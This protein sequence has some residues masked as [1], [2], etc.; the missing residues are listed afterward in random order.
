VP[1]L[2]W[3]YQNW[4]N[5]H[6]WEKAGDEWSAG[7][8]DA[9]SQWYGTILP[10]ISCFL[11]AKSILEIAPGFGRW[12]QFLLGNCDEYFGVDISERCIAKCK[13]R[14]GASNRVHFVQ[15]DGVSLN[16]IPD[17]HVDFVF[18]FDSLVHVDIDVIREYIWQIC[19]KL[20][21]T[22]IAFVHHSNAA[23]EQCDRSQAASIARSLNVSSA[24]VK[25][26]V[27]DC[28]AKV[29]IQEEVT[30]AGSTRID[31]L[32]T[33]GPAD[34]FPD[35]PYTLMQNDQFMLEMDL[36]RNYHRPYNFR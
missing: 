14:F 16:M 24:I 20:T 12:T 11:P 19:Q 30:W 7:W 36:I 31:C 34:L 27:E 8:G 3:N 28:G 22:G 4:N 15:N 21:K 13:E 6:G 18:S 17:Q 32:S 10:R 1:D 2:N 33:F 35:R 5:V 25:Q 26:L 23:S 9:R 29:F